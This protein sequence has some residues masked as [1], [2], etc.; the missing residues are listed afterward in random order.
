MRGAPAEVAARERGGRGSL[1][2]VSLC[3]SSYLSW[4]LVFSFVLWS[5][6]FVLWSLFFVLCS[7]FFG[8]WSL[9][10]VFAAFA[11]LGCCDLCHRSLCEFFCEFYHLLALRHS[12]DVDTP[13]GVRVCSSPNEPQGGLK[14][15]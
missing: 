2:E 5:L 9:L 15:S 8:L 3:L 4:S 14:M 7:L 13:A 12:N 6:V 1:A 10:F 11:F